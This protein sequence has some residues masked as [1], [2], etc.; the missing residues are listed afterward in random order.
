[1][2]TLPP[3]RDDVMQKVP[4]IGDRAGGA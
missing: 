2:Q 3:E 4:G 1:L